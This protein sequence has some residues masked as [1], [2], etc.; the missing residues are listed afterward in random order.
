MA[1]KIEVLFTWTGHFPS[2]F[3][4][5]PPVAGVRIP[6]GNGADPALPSPGRGSWNDLG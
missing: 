2:R 3:F 4:S 1:L 5:S 6:A